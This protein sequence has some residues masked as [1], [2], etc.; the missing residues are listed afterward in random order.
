MRRLLIALIVSCV[1]AQAYAYTNIIVDEGFSDAVATCTSIQ[2]GAWSASTT[3]NCNREP[4][5]SDWVKIAHAVTISGDRTA[6]T[7]Y[8]AS[9][10]SLTC[11]GAGSLTFS[12]TAPEATTRFYTGLLVLGASSCVRSSKTPWARTT[13]GIANGA[14]AITVDAC[15]GW[16]MGDR[17]VIGDTREAADLGD[18]AHTIWFPEVRTIS[19]IASCV[20]TLSSATGHAYTTARDHAGV[21]ERTVPVGNLTRD[22]VFKSTTSATSRGHILFNAD[23]V[24]D[25]EYVAVQDMG[26]TTLATLDNTTNH[27]GRYPLHL[28]HLNSAALVKGVVVER[29]LKWA[30]TVHASNGS[31]LQ[32]NIAYDALGWGFGTEDGTETDNIFQGNL[33]ILIDGPFQSF[34]SGGSGIS[35]ENGTNGDGFWLQGPYNQLIGNVAMN[36]QEDCFQIWD[37]VAPADYLHK[38]KDNEAI[39]CNEG[40]SLWKFGDFTHITHIDHFMEWH[41]FTY[42]FYQYGSANLVF[43]NFYSRSDLTTFGSRVHLKQN[44]FGDYDPVW[45]VL[46]RPDIQNKDIGFREPYGVSG[47][48]VGS[49]ERIVIV[50]DPYFYNTVDVL[51][52]MQ[53]L[54]AGA[55][56]VRTEFIN[57]IHGNASGTHYEKR[58]SGAGDATKRN[59]IRV[60]N[61]QGVVG[62]NFEVFGAAQDA[63][64]HFGPTGEYSLQ[65]GC[66]S[67]M[68]TNQ[69]CFD[70]HGVSIYGQITPV[71]AHTRANMNTVCGFFCGADSAVQGKVLD[72]TITQGTSVTDTEGAAWTVNGSFTALRNGSTTSTVCYDFVVSSTD[73]QIYCLGAD[74]VWRYWSGGSGGSWIVYSLVTGTVGGVESRTHWGLPPDTHTLPTSTSGTFIRNGG[75]VTSPYAPFFVDSDKLIWGALD[76][77]ATGTLVRTGW[78]ADAYSEA[79]P[80]TATPLARSTAGTPWSGLFCVGTVWKADNDAYATRSATTLTWTSSASPPGCSV[81][82]AAI[83]RRLRFRVP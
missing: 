25:W 31:T 37:F 40:F 80:Q 33:A 65:T 70:A 5:A 16:V 1:A 13:A 64:I 55:E 54:A 17:I 38:F 68:M 47:P 27:I 81:N 41:N 21:V 42:G 71:A 15:A 12:D 83:R 73:S 28:H 74:F 77:P 43:T 53:G 44:W 67:A 75:F 59:R 76:S 61:Y 79:L 2:D 62:D 7:V 30:Y 35:P 82:G 48:Q 8:V 11:N 50:V 14:T 78:H 23:A 51:A 58:Y 57:P 6:W 60:T 34:S 72:F 10:G 20:I 39:A 9:T 4:L 52:E 3:W 29:S 32:D 36:A 56:H 46:L 69:Q 22:F 24:I 66:P 26:R 63:T 19:A 49:G 18:Y 45:T